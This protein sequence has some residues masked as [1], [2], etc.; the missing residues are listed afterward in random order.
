MSMYPALRLRRSRTTAWSRALV[1]ETHLAP[2]QLIWPLFVTSGKGVEE[3]IASLPGVDRKSTRLN[4]S[5][6]D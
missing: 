5:H 3:P 1:R 2:A 4:S 6:V